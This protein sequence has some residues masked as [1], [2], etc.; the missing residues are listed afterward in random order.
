MMAVFLKLGNKWEVTITVQTMTK[1]WTR[2]PCANKNISETSA[3]ENLIKENKTTNVE[4][5]VLLAALGK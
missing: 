2:G 5:N 1:K 3:N 4:K